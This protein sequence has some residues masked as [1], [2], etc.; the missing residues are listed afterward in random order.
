MNNTMV[1][2][3]KLGMFDY[4]AVVNELASEFYNEDGDYQPH[5]GLINAMRVF[6]NACVKSS[7]FDQK[8]D[9][10]VIDPLE[11]SE[12]LEDEEFNQAFNEA[13]TIC[14]IQLDFA[15]AFRDAMDM[16][17]TKKNSAHTLFEKAKKIAQSISSSMAGMMT[18]ENL[19]RIDAITDKIRDGSLDVDAFIESYGSS[20]MFQNLLA[21]KK[22]AEMN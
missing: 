15:N 8:F 1:I 17:N 22:K 3:T 18:K 10:D 19:D 21:A 2:E 9:H 20:E 4:L 14:A 6:Y 13:I 16:V 12:I 11:I 5:I 7:K